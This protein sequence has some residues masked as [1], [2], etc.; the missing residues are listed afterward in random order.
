MTI[1]L[2]LFLILL[3]NLFFLPDSKKDITSIYFNTQIFS[4]YFA[5]FSNHYEQDHTQYASL[6]LCHQNTDSILTHL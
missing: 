6:D 3:K 4:A 2:C 5:L 1:F